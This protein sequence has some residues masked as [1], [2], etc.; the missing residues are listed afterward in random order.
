MIMN[1]KLHDAAVRKPV[2][3]SL[4][5]HVEGVSC[6]KPDLGDRDTMLAGVA[7]R[8]ATKVPKADQMYLKLFC[9]FVREWV[10][11]NLVPLDSMSDTS[12]E[13]W[14]K[15]TNYPEWRRD[16][17]RRVNARL[18]E[19]EDDD[20]FEVM[21]F[22]KDE[23]YADYKHGRGINARSDAAKCLFGPYFKLIEEVLYKHPA[24]IKHVPVADRPQYIKDLLERAATEAA[25]SDYTSFEALFVEE[26]MSVCEFELYDHMTSALPRHGFF[27]RMCRSVLGGVNVCY[28]KFFTV[29]LHAVRMSGEMCTS[30]GNGFTNLMA[31]L[32]TFER[33]GSSRNSIRGVVEGDDGLFVFDG[34]AP[35]PDDFAKLGLVIKL[36]M[37][38]DLAA[39]SFCGLIFDPD[40]LVNI[41]CPFKA[42]ATFGWTSSR[43][44]NTSS[45]TLKAMLRCKALSLAH[46]Y[47]G[48]PVFSALARYGLRVTD[49]VAVSKTLRV[50]NARGWDEWHRVQVLQAIENCRESRPVPMRTRL[51]MEEKFKLRVTDQLYIEAYLDSLREIRP[52]V[53][54]HAMFPSAW[55]DYSSRY[56]R[57]DQGDRVDIDVDRNPWSVYSLFEQKGNILRPKGSTVRLRPRPLRL[58]AWRGLRD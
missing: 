23:F 52:L 8:F 10:R 58:P 50:A 2:S 7:K 1:T 14:I 24:F 54:D 47:P 15:G 37:H 17:L 29:L 56:V 9:L 31:A 6:P 27:M 49:D 55:V 36:E 21:S 30:L 26:L 35:T 57:P 42:L 11:H 3:V 38:R 41:A 18:E 32:F 4:G 33:C 40:D 16:E 53:I 48:A 13:T 34:P 12:F 5:C 45:K 25:A 19:M 39:A 51:L 22:M 20:I 44:R 43:Y 46:Q 28:Y